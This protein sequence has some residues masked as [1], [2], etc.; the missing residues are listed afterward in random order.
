MV[1]WRNSEVNDKDENAE[2]EE[3]GVHFVEMPDEGANE[4]PFLLFIHITS[5]R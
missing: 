3:D 1:L 2:D 5:L 4:G